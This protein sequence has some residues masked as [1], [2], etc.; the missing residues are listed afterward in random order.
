MPQPANTKELRSDD[1]WLKATPKLRAPILLPAAGPRCLMSDHI[2]TQM[3]QTN[4]VKIMLQTDAKSQ[5][6]RTL[7]CWLE[8]QFLGVQ[9][10]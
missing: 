9:I 8:N 4:P 10:K 6:S 1:H 2:T 5:I 7:K 3:I